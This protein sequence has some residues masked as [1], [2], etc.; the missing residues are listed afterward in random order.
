MDMAAYACFSAAQHA[1]CLPTTHASHPARFSLPA[2]FLSSPSW[3]LTVLTLERETVST[4]LN[5]QVLISVTALP[6]TQWRLQD[7]F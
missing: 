3:V 5:I 2:A 4:G 6:G 1:L 7:Q